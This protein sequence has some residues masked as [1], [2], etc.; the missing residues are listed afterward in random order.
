MMR[1][2][3]LLLGVFAS[4]WAQSPDVKVLKQ[5]A[6]EM[7]DARRKFAQ[8]MVD[9]IFSF[10]ELGYQEVETSKYITGIL[11]KEGFQVTRGVAGMPTAFVASWGSGKPVIGLMADIDGLP[12]TSQKP[13]VAYHDP[14][15]QGGPGHGEG[16]NAGQAV[17][18]TAAL[19]IK[20]IMQKYN[21]PGTL[22]IYPGVAEE[23]LGSRNYMVRAG[24]PKDLDVMLSTHI[25]STFGTNW[26]GGSNTGLVS[27]IYSFHGRSAHSAGS[28]WAGRS[29]LDAVE[30]MNIGWNYRREHLRLDQRSHY[31]IVNGGNQ[32]NVVPS[33]AS[34]WY[35]FRE[36]DYENINSCT[37]LER[38]S[39]MRRR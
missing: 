16:H 2:L 36:G 26:G 28:P 38:L 15:I 37:T 8:V 30:L 39:P 9:S 32:P 19:V 25:A 12:E 29:A 3:M 23:Q 4:G 35:Y 17:T 22:R 20:S 27:T 5:A 11:E 21:I 6:V 10:S 14:L 24:L 31:V 18:V 1:I 34:V 13:G 7:T 33:E